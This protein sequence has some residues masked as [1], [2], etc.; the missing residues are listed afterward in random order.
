MVLKGIFSKS[1]MKLAKFILLL[2]LIIP[3]IGLLYGQTDQWSLANLS[4]ASTYNVNGYLVVN[5]G[6]SVFYKSG[7]SINCIYWA[8]N[9]WNWSGLNNVNNVAG[10]LVVD[11]SDKIFYKTTD[12]KINCIYYSNGQWVWSDLGGISGNSVS[13]S[14]A[15]SPSGSIFYKTTDNSINCIY[16]ANNTWNRSTLNGAAGTNV[17][18]SLA[19]SQ[20]GTVFYKTTDNRINCIYNYNNAWYRS[21]LGG[22]SGNSVLGG[23]TVSSSGNVYYVTTDHNIN[24][25]YWSNNAWHWS[26]LNN[27]ADGIAE[28]SLVSG[29]G[30][31]YFPTTNNG[32]KAIYWD[33]YWKLDNL[34]YASGSTVSGFLALSQSNNT[35]FYKSTNNSIYAIYKTTVKSGLSENFEE[36][37][38]NMSSL[39]VYPMPAQDHI[40]V[41]GA[42]AGSIITIV[43]S[44]GMT[45]KEVQVEET[46]TTLDVSD[47]PRGVYHVNTVEKGVAKGTTVILTK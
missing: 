14:L 41:E 38:T 22:L 32:L 15:V 29:D 18:G 6:G 2:A 27:V 31:I 30:K 17:K 8:N 34:A 25:L 33:G 37:S 20:S 5:S 21:E 4:Q 23:L 42:D 10:Y 7:N 11:D 16:W 3:Q 12:N 40:T 46:K 24:C 9:S 36:E 19:I 47:L 1:K 45:V 13:G 26:G 44:T 43:N 35:V 39:S 28:C